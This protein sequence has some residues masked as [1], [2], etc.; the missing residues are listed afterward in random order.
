M[1][2]LISTLSYRTQTIIILCG[3]FIKKMYRTYKNTHTCIVLLLWFFSYTLFPHIFYLNSNAHR[4]TQKTLARTSF[5]FLCVYH[6]L[7]I[8]FG[9]VTCDLCANI[10]G[11][12]FLL[13]IFSFFIYYFFT[14]NPMKNEVKWNIWNRLKKFC[15]RHM[16]EYMWLLCVYWK[17]VPS[18]D[19]D[20]WNEHT[21]LHT[22]KL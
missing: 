22:K 15:V 12:S 17:Q 7:C 10:Y 5:L 19:N 6:Q 13:C 4:Y 1:Y 11:N 3:I 21:Y 2:A 8:M 18:S 20:L 16:C 14:W 9:H